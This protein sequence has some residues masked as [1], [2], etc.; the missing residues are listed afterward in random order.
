MR[1]VG[2]RF[3]VREK[4]PI[5]ASIE[6]LMGSPGLGHAPSR[7][8][9]PKC[10][11]A[12]EEHGRGSASEFDEKPGPGHLPIANDALGRNLQHFRRFLDAQSSEESELDHLCFAR[13][14]LNTGRG[15][16]SC[17]NAALE[18]SG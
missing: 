12:R 8:S 7:S 1:S 4:V 3:F 5:S 14:N 18:K 16:R 6:A 10:P 15:W 2:R 13:V 17:T 9:F 11:V